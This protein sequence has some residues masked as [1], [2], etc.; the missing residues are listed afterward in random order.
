MKSLI[1]NFKYFEIYYIPK[2]SDTWVDLLSTLAN[3]KKVE[4]LKIIIQE[5]L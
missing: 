5:T 2:E 4:Y 3:A 1:D